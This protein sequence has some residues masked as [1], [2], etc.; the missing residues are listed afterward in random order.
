MKKIFGLIMVFSTL[1]IPT[2]GTGSLSDNL[3]V[4]H[5]FSSG[6]T[7]SSVE[8]NENFDSIFDEL[9]KLRKYV[10][11]NGNIVAEFISFKNSYALGKMIKTIGYR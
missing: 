7:I 11:S 2:Y 10:Y 8:M 1:V 9:N 6:E 3:T 4:L 5:T